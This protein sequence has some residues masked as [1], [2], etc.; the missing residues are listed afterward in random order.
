VR[1]AVVGAGVGGLAAAL[2]LAVLGH[3]VT[4]LEAAPDVGGK[5][6]CHAAEGFRFDT[7]PS[8][9]TMPWAL[10]DTF[11]AAGLELR[12]HLE[13]VP[14]APLCR[15]TFA[16]GGELDT[17]ADVR[18]TAAAMDALS[19]GAGAAWEGLMRQAA[20]TWELSRRV[21][22]EQPLRSP[23]DLVRRSAGLA[24]ARDVLAHTTLARLAR[25]T[26]AD[27]RLVRLLERYATYQGAD[28]RRAPGTLACIPYAE[29][30]HGAWHVS[31]GLHR[32]A[33]ALREAAERAGATVR[34]DSAVTRVLVR[35]RRARGVV[36]GG[37]ELA[38]DAVVAN[39]DALHLYRDL[40]GDRRL[41]R[42]V[43]RAPRSLSGFALMLGVRGRTPGLPH[44]SVW[45][46]HDYRAEFA[47]VFDDP[48]PASDP[49]IYLCNPAATDPSVAPTGDEAWFVLVNAPLQGPVD[50]DRA[51]PAY[52]ER[53]LDR[54]DALGLEARRR[55]VTLHLRSP[56]DLERE[57]RTP[58][59][60]IYGT[61]SNGPRAA[62]LR[63]RN[64]APVRGLYLAGGSAHPGGG[65]PLVLLSAGIVARAIGRA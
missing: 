15:Y 43:A 10:E 30:A 13:L 55:L 8:L 24:D 5:A 11:A 34:T 38:A 61:A 54:L 31:G 12:D 28:P 64:A 36:A 47:D 17:H 18:R 49:T 14:V 25:R 63:P 19:P 51:A 48:R 7:G 37:E 20:R 65:L 23:L 35:D 46:P 22:L 39:A 40:V 42:R 41:A 50:W 44:H 3:E 9:L 45:F 53:L 58:G 62:F 2:R 21:F 57:T 1:I 26:F 4:V 56:A 32:I 6:G 59:G 60:A 52:V 16:E 29:A 27:P 33:I